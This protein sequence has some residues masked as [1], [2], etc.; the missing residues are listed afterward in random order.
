VESLECRVIG[1][2][3]VTEGVGIHRQHPLTEES[4]IL[5]GNID[6]RKLL[7]EIGLEA[8]LVCF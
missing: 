8:L 7:G 6:L 3:I 1:G 5:V 2:K 4:L